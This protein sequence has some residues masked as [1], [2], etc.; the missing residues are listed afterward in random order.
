VKVLFLGTNGWYDTGAGNTICTLIKAGEATVILDAG[1]GLHK[2]NGHIAPGEKKPIY[3]FLSHFHFDHIVGLHLLNMFSFPGKLVIGGP[4]GSKDILNRVVNRP[5]T[6]SFAELPYETTVLE[7]PEEKN[8]LEIEVEAKPLLH[9]DLTIGFRMRL[10]GKVISYCPDTGYCENAVLLSRNADLLIAECAYRSG[11]SS[12]SWPHLNPET[13]A[14]IAL[15]AG[16]K[17]LVLTH[18]DASLYTTRGMRKKS[19]TAARGI[20]PNTVAAMDDMQI[21]V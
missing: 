9:P 21:D 2:L 8:R 17:R 4:A 1:N 16:A 18:F 14:A 15:E 10:D 20:F 12:E 5:F 19:E 7:L 13:A 6:A 3:L 11:E